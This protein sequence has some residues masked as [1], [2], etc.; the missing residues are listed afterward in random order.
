MLNIITNILGILIIPF[1]MY[2]F[3]TL[4]KMD[5]W[6]FFLMMIISPIFLYVKSKGFNTLINKMVDNQ[7]LKK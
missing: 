5:G 7:I 4:D 1:T 3:Y 6:D 2:S